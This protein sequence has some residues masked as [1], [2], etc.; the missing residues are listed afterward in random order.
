MVG[1][2]NPREAE[3]PRERARGREGEIEGTQWN[4]KRQRM[5]EQ[6]DDLRSASLQRQPAPH[7]RGG[8]GGGGGG[9]G[10]PSRSARAHGFQYEDPFEASARKGSAGDGIDHRQGWTRTPEGGGR[11]GGGHDGR[12]GWGVRDQE[13]EMGG[14]RRGWDRDAMIDLR[15]DGAEVGVA[16]GGRGEAEGARGG[17][18][19][20]KNDFISGHDKLRQDMAEKNGRRGAGGAGA[21]GRAGGGGYGDWQQ[22]AQYSSSGASAKTLGGKR[23]LFLFIIFIF[24]FFPTLPLKLS[25]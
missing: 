5:L 14:G 3:G 23:S 19:G 7:A 4:L 12:V 20:P 6:D 2:R 24:Y 16:R 10:W 25:A 9:D 22:G 17:G 11:G 8:G 15:G 13:S 18:A 1:A 21:Q